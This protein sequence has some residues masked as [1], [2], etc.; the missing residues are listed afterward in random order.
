MKHLCSM[1][2]VEELIEAVGLE[3]YHATYHKC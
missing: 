1:N 3:D 2:I